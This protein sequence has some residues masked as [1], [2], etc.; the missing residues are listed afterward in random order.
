MP[1]LAR[2]AEARSGNTTAPP[3]VFVYE[4]LACFVATSFEQ[5]C[6]FRL[7]R[8]GGRGIRPTCAL[9]YGLHDL[10]TRSSVFAEG[11]R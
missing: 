7:R 10:V 11:L 3:I 8:V 1:N 2:K 9:G 6:L 4:L 5:L